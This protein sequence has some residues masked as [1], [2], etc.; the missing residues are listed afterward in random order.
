MGTT[1]DAPFVSLIAHEMRSPLSAIRG[2][3][4]LLGDHHE[5][6]SAE[7]RG[8]LL[9]VVDD[10]ALQ[11]DRVIQDLIVLS[12]LNDGAL[13]IEPVD[14]DLVKIIRDVARALNSRFPERAVMIALEDDVPAAYAD[15]IRVRQIVTNLVANAISYS[16][17]TSTVIVSIVRDGDCVRTSVFN[18]GH[19]I[20]PSEQAKLFT[21]FAVLSERTA[22]STGLGLFIAKGLVE[23]MHGAIGFS[24][25]S[26]EHAL[27]WFTLPLGRGAGSTPPVAEKRT[28][29]LR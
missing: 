3:V 7:R 14:V 5:G 6:L 17:E 19:G 27:F 20:P 29:A 10:S 26:D 21:P 25:Q 16:Q 2:A 13:A 28:D 12:R 24:T 15:A 9:A 1:L 11:I 4:A 22:E 18:E 8:E 23:A